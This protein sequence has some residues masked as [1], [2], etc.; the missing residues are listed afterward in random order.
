MDLVRLNS[1]MALFMKD[2]GVR[3]NG[4]GMA[5][6]FGLTMLFT[7]ASSEMGRK[8]VKVVSSGMMA[9]FMKGILK[10]MI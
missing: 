8:M 1:V 4:M 3:I 2:N 5:R 10:M 9:R 6:R 7:R